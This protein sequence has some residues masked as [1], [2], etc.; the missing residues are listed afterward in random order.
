MTEMSS[1]PPP[2]RRFLMVHGVQHRRP[3]QHWLWWLTEALRQRGEQVLYPQFPAPE[4]PSMS[5][6]IDLLHAELAQLGDQERV[7]VC[8]SLGC[9]LW[10]QAAQTL[11]A[12][13]RVTRVLLVSPL[14]AQAFTAA[15]GNEEFKLER[16]DRE[17]LKA[18]SAKP[19]HVVVSETDPYAPADPRAWSAALDLD[20]DILPAA[21]H[22]TPADGYGQWPAALDW[23]LHEKTPVSATTGP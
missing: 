9:A 16:V 12:D 19:P 11:P 22:I 6:W 14:G 17:L 13:L 10:L 20:C 1:S 8:H 2:A 3:R 23:C 15:N 5:E 21:G 4:Q 7:V 18:A